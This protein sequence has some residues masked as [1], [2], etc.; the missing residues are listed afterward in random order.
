MNNRNSKKRIKR[1]GDWKY[2]WINYGRKPSKSKENRN[3][4]TQSK[5]GPRQVEPKQAH[6]KTHYN[7][8]SKY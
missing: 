2:I 6:T 3:Q 8:N 7:K 4:D 1:K 5:E